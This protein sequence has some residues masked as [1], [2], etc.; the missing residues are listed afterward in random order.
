MGVPRGTSAILE[1]WQD[2][3]LKNLLGSTITW[4]SVREMTAVGVLREDQRLGLMEVGV[5][6]G[7]VAALTPS[8]RRSPSPSPRCSFWPRGGG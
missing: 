8:P 3:V 5:P 1:V 2:K 4:E 7:V 6:M